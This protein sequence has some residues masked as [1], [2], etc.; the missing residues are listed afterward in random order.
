MKRYA[1]IDDDRKQSE[2]HHH[3]DCLCTF[4]QYWFTNDFTSGINYDAASHREADALIAKELT[5]LSLAERNRAEEE[6]HGVIGCSEEDPE[7]VKGQ[8]AMLETEIASIKKKPAYERALFLSPKYVNDVK[9]RLMFLRAENFDAVKAA[10]RLVKH[11][12]C[13]LEYFGLDKLVKNITQDD[14]DDDDRAALSSGCSM[15]LNATDNIGRRIIFWT[16]S[17]EKYKCYKNSVSLLFAEEYNQSFHA[18]FS[19]V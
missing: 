17:A 9:F 14:L 15:V 13:K 12:E 7:F 8:L 4:F 6:I 3:G 18:A 2:V 11:F 10:N 16:R 1:N 5:S 19:L